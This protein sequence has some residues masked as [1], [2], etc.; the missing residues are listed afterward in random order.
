[1]S[2]AVVISSAEYFSAPSTEMVFTLKNTVI[3][4]IAAAVSSSSST[5]RPSA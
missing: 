2:S 1:M 5:A 3:I 4:T